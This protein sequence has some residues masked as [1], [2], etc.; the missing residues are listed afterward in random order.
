MGDSEWNFGNLTLPQLADFF[1]YKEVIV[2]I[3]TSTPKGEGR[4]IRWKFYE[5]VIRYRKRQDE[6]VKFQ[7]LILSLNE[8]FFGRYDMNGTLRHPDHAYFSI[9][10]SILLREALTKLNVFLHL[11]YKLELKISSQ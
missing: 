2:W 5:N 8:S 3:H 11:R 1:L 6:I 10:F 4:G 7:T 9:L